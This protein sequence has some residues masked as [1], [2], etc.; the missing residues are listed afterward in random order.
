M[1]KKISI[2]VDENILRQ[3]DNICDKRGVNRSR[4][5]EILLR[6]DF[7]EL[8]V[9]ILA[10]GGKINGIDKSLVEYNGK[11]LIDHQ[12]RYLKH[13]DFYNINVATDSKLVEDHIRRNYKN[14]NVLFEKELL[15]TGGA[16]KYWGSKLGKEILMLHGDILS[17]IELKRLIEFHHE[18]KSAATLV[19]KTMNP[20]NQYGVARLEGSRIYEFME[21]PQKSDSYLCFTGIAVFNKSAFEKLDDKGQYQTQLN[22]IPHKYGY[23]FE[24]FWKAFETE[25]DLIPL[26]N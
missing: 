19:L 21:K 5:I 10:G 15:G 11:K 9:L 1:K 4:Y 25:K 12:I 23:V 22:K 7:E 2:T 3:I 16:L 8:P 24:G 26:T 17:G 14:V 6:E 13:N 18:N 20:Y